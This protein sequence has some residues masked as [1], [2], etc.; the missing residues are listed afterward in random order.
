MLVKE[1]VPGVIMKIENISH[2]KRPVYFPSTENKKLFD[3]KEINS[4]G[5]QVLLSVK[6]KNQLIHFMSL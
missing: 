6:S 1:H 5:I 2:D 3:V 4:N